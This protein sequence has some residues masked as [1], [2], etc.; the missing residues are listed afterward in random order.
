MSLGLYK[1]VAP[2][3]ASLELVWKLLGIPS[4]RFAK[5]VGLVMEDCIY[6]SSPLNFICIFSFLN[7]NWH[8]IY[9]C[10]KHELPDFCSNVTYHYYNYFIEIVSK[11]YKTDTSLLTFKVLI[12]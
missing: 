7:V 8:L 5:C 1:E 3:E 12:I 11:V 9:H 10:T 4:R 2:S 6:N